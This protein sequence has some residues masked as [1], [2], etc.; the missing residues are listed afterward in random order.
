MSSLK[1]QLTAFACVCESIYVQRLYKIR[2]LFP[3]DIHHDP[4]S[5]DTKGEHYQPLHPTDYS[6]RLIISALGQKH[7][8]SGGT[9][10]PGRK[11][12]WGRIEL[13]HSQDDSSHQPGQQL[14]QEYHQK[15]RLGQ[16]IEKCKYLLIFFR[17]NPRD[18]LKSHPPLLETEI[19][20]LLP[21]RVC[22]GSTQLHGLLRPVWYAQYVQLMVP[23]HRIARLDAVGAFDGRGSGEERGWSVYA[24]HNCRGHVDG[25][26]FES[27]EAGRSQPKQSTS[28]DG[29]VVAPV[30]GG[31]D[32]LRRGT[33]G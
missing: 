6:T 7:E 16:F 9:S 3:A 25:C 4:V 2:I 5:I 1:S 14:R 20:Q 12:P 17:K 11:Q 24:Q 10:N 13:Q 27:E 18:P 23:D 32:Q 8:I 33:A 28:T 15:T 26:V 22:G 21:V 30:P 31:I 29:T 19:L